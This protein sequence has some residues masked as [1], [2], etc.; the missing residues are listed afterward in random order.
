MLKKASKGRNLLTGLCLVSCFWL[1]AC[2]SLFFQPMKQHLATPE[3]YNIEY[4]D[5]TFKGESGLN[6]HGWWFPASE[7]SK[8][9]VLFLHGNGE[10]ISTHSGMV[11][12]LTGHQYDVFIF[13]YR[14]YGKSEGYAFVEG[15]I[16]DIKS[17]REYVNARRPSDKK[18]FMLGHSLGASLG[19]Y[20]LAKDN[21][22]IDGAIF[23]SAFSDYQKIAREMMATSWLTWAFQWPFSLTI[24]NEYSPAEVVAS[25]PDI[26]RLFMYSVE[27][28]MISAEHTVELFNK[29]TGEK[30]LEKVTGQHNRIFAQTANQQVILRY[31]DKWSE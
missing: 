15:A 24:S 16:A 10:N 7:E 18:L 28:Q 30:Y 3:Q 4:E 9:I 25:T 19:I 23:V 26:P 31:L 27:D 12:W 8:A 20:N 1:S 6:L 17:A 29:A 21:G 14:G 22:P 2:T 13:D 11:H 5:V